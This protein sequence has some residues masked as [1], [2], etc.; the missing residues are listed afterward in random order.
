MRRFREMVAAMALLAFL[1]PWARVV[2]VS[3]HLAAAH[4]HAS[5][6][7]HSS[8]LEDALHG[9]HHTRG[10]ASHQHFLIGRDVVLQRSRVIADL[11]SPPSEPSLAMRAIL[12]TAGGLGCVRRETISDHG[13]P[14]GPRRAILRI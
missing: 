12:P 10:E 5:G 9:H 8:D 2:S 4:H 6:R 11:M 3:A 13:P 1:L 7:H 14:R